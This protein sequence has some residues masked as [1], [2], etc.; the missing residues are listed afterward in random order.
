MS[1]DI[2]AVRKPYAY[3]KIPVFLLWELCEGFTSL[4]TPRCLVEINRVKWAE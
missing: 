1:E 4:I 2:A 3:V